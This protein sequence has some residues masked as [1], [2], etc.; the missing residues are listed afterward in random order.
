VHARPEQRRRLPDRSLPLHGQE[1]HRGVDLERG[2]NGAERLEAHVA[3]LLDLAHRPRR[4]AGAL[5]DVGRAQSETH[6]EAPRRV[7]HLRALAG[8]HAHHAADR[9]HELRTVKQIPAVRDCA[10]VRGVARR[11]AATG[12]G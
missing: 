5:G 9:T 6:A 2:G 1:Q 8:R 11:C 4:D 7:E 12:C 3:P 10:A